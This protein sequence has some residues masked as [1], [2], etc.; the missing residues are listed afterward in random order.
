MNL[1]DYQII[2]DSEDNLYVVWTKNVRYKARDEVVGTYDATAQEIYAMVAPGVVEIS[3][4][5]ADGEAF[6]LG[7]GF[8]VDDQGLIVTNYHVMEGAYS[9]E[10]SVLGGEACKVLYVVDYDADLDLALIRADVRGNAVLTIS[11]TPPVTGQVVYALGSSLG[12]TGTFSDGIVS[13]ASREIEGVDF[14]QITAPISQGN[15]GGPLIDEHGK[16]VGI[17]CKTAAEGQN[18]NFAIAIHELDRLS[19]SGST[20]IAEFGALTT[21][22]VGPET[23]EVDYSAGFYPYADKFENEPNDNFLL[24]DDLEPGV[25]FAGE[26]TNAEDLDFYYFYLEEKATIQVGVKFEDVIHALYTNVA[27]VVIKGDDIEVLDTLPYAEGDDEHTILGKAME[28]E[29]GSYFLVLLRDD[30][31]P[32]METSYYM[33]T[34]LISE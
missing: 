12:L 19:R 5:N 13:T 23:D 28:L 4:Y 30:S 33:L 22:E 2:T 8:F 6:A 29:A 31:K 11:D 15:S 1:T 25:V 26:V 32:D 20:P 24:S 14:I 21:P 16:V 27:I 7:S 3:V 34:Y 18:L 9:A 17:N 10:V